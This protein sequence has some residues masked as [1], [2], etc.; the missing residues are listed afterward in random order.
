MQQGAQTRAYRD[1]FRAFVIDLAVQGHQQLHRL[2]FAVIGT[3]RLSTMDELVG[4]MLDRMAQN[5]QGVAGLR[6]GVA[7]VGAY[8][9]THGYRRCYLNSEVGGH[10]S[11]HGV[12]PHSVL[13]PLLFCFR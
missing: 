13:R 1:H 9:R 12:Y 5:L 8:M 2:E 10:G 11:C 4:K 7:A 3:H 6:H